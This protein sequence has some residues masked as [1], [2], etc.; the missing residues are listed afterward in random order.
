MS[1][2]FIFEDGQTT[3]RSVSLKTAGN[4]NPRDYLGEN[5]NAPFYEPVLACLLENTP[6]NLENLYSQK[7]PLSQRYV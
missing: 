4:F 5:K 2:K 1:K 6:A 3:M 7:V